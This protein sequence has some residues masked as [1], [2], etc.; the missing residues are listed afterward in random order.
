MRVEDSE[1]YRY[2]FRTNLVFSLNYRDT[3][4][5]KGEGQ[6]YHSTGRYKYRIIDVYT[7]GLSLMFSDPIL[8]TDNQMKYHR[9]I[10][11]PGIMFFD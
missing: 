11:S 9:I 10:L 5:K 7:R 3:R 2:F 8:M 6:Q 1:K 4:Y